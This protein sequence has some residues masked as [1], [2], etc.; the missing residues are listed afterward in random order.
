MTLA[1]FPTAYFMAAV[2]INESAV[3]AGNAWWEDGTSRPIIWT[4]PAQAQ[5][6]GISGAAQDINN[7]GHVVGN[8]SPQGFAG[9]GE[10]Y[11]WDAT[12]GATLLGTLGGT[13]SERERGQ[14]GG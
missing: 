11:I 8:T 5:E 4:D 9:I 2:A 7:R 1:R 3:V 12:N 13:W 6:L 14:C 10:A